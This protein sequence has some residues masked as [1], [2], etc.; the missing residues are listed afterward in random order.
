[1]QLSL[2][3]F[4]FVYP[5]FLWGPWNILF[6]FFHI[7]VSYFTFPLKSQAPTPF[8]LVQDD[9][10]TSFSVTVFGTHVYVWFSPM[11][12]V[13]H[14]HCGFV[15]CYLYHTDLSTCFI[16]LA[17]WKLLE[18]SVSVL[19]LAF[20]PEALSSVF[21]VRGTQKY[22]Q[23][24]NERMDR[25]LLQVAS[26]CDIWTCLLFL[27]NVENNFPILFCPAKTPGMP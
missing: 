10:Y 13:K 8:F 5:L 9:I 16:S 26:S 2:L 22:I 15:S 27:S 12:V 1:M 24:I 4:L 17:K 11:Y 18:G 25:W 20:Y 7:L 6:T 23:E 3:K 21:S 14:K 19:L